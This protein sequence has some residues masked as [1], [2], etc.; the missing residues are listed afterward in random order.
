[1][2]R[3]TQKEIAKKVGI[4]PSF[5]SEILNGKKRPHWKTAKK[6]AAQT[7]TT[8]TLWMDGSVEALRTA[9]SR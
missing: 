8:P 4:S 5:L 1:M 2:W 6:L 7:G 3:T 9:I